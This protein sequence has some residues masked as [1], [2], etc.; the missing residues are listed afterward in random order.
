MVRTHQI[1]SICSREFTRKSNAE[2]H[3]ENL[4]ASQAHIVPLKEFR[5]GGLGRHVRNTK[6]GFSPTPNSHKKED[7]LT[8]VLERIGKEF[9]GCEHEVMS[10]PP[11]DRADIL[12][13]VIILAVRSADP[14]ESMRKSLKSMRRNNL[15]LKM[16]RYVA[17][18][19]DLPFFAAKN[20][21]INTL[22]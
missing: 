18:A 2:R 21:L 20:H 1:C 22:E 14:K 19:L 10:L 15:S 9:E 8:D 3:N 11:Q 12:T 5:F 7:L 17:T 6:I 4:H 13:Q 16:I